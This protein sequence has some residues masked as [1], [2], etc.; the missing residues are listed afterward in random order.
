MAFLYCSAGPHPH[1][2]PALASL[3]GAGGA[4]FLD[5]AVGS[6]KRSAALLVKSVRER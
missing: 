2:L 3:D 4:E 6:G 5:E 1:A